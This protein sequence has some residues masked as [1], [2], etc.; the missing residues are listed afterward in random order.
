MK[1]ILKSTGLALA[2]LM[3]LVVTT[4]T[5]ASAKEVEV[6]D[7]YDCSECVDKICTV[8]NRMSSQINE[9]QTMDQ[10]SAIQFDQ[11]TKGLGIDEVPEGCGVYELTTA[12]KN[13]INAAWDAVIDA[14]ENKFVEF[15]GGFITRQQIQGETDPI[16]NAFKNA[17]NESITLE[18]I[19]TNLSSM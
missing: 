13:K 6:Y 18:D 10:F 3:A 9:C 16:R 15:T 1:R 19:G 2:L 5:T 14:M 11:L 12:D 7:I 4:T 8:L 17:I